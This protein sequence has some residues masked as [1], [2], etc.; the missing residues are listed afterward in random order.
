[1]I[2][3]GDR[4]KAEKIQDEWVH[5]LGNLTLSGYNSKLSNQSYL[6]NR[7]KEFLEQERIE[8]A[9]DR[10]GGDQQVIDIRQYIDRLEINREP[11][12]LFL[13]MILDQGKTARVSE[14]I[15]SLLDLSAQE[16]ALVRVTRLG[17][18][19][20]QADGN[21]LTPMEIT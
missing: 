17:L 8:I 1:M 21:L 15:A 4:E 3:D 19:V 9:R 7:I 16:L 2:A 5:C 6:S 11:G 12:S 18:F 20:H 13:S 10:K 14:I